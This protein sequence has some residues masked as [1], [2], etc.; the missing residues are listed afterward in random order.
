MDKEKQ[1]KNLG[2]EILRFIVVGGGATLIDFVCEW[3]VL[4]IIGDKMGT[5]SVWPQV[6]AVTVGFLISTI[7]NYLLSL[8]W[9]FQ[10]VKD[11]KKAHSKSYLFYFVIL[12]AI[13][14]GI[15]IG[16]QALGQWICQSNFNININEVKFSNIFSQTAGPFWAFAIVF[17]LKT[18]VT[19][20]YNY[21]SRKFLLFR[22]PK[23][24]EKA[25]AS[26]DVKESSED[27]S[28]PDSH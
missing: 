14:L 20:V 25:A 4:A 18:C 11:E 24:G 22:A 15:G 6:I 17:V 26:A 9:V 1:H 28:E 13:G 19:L 8:L 12:S 27:H 3:A 23:D 10:N 2:L 16:L 21:V 7:F 5:T